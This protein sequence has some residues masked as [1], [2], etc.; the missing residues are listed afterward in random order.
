M[1]ELETKTAPLTPVGYR[2]KECESIKESSSAWNKDDEKIA[3]EEDL[4]S[5]SGRGILGDHREGKKIFGVLAEIT[6]RGFLRYTWDLVKPL[7]TCLIEARLREFKERVAV[8]FGPNPKQ[9]NYQGDLDYLN[10]LVS[11]FGDYPFTIQRICEL[12]VPGAYYSSFEQLVWAL[13]KCLMVTQTLKPQHS[14]STLECQHALPSIGELEKEMKGLQ[15]PARPQ[16]CKSHNPQ[17]LWIGYENSRDSQSMSSGDEGERPAREKGSDGQQQPEASTS[18]ENNG[19]LTSK[20]GA[21][22][23]SEGPIGYN[24]NSSL[25]EFQQGKTETETEQIIK[26]HDTVPYSKNSIQPLHESLDLVTNQPAHNSSY[27]E[28]NNMMLESPQKKHKI[29]SGE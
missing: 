1:I 7:I 26:M 29:N 3:S 19:V 6:T 2:K 14:S 12:L 15:K 17:G 5:F 27:L 13:E 22:V 16:R 24:N 4:L 8:E 11:S 20:S 9:K 25:S 10:G 28:T 23:F 18:K 21:S